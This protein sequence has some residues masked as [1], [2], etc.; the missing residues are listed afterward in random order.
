[1]NPENEARKAN[2]D[3]D[4]KVTEQLPEQDLKHNAAELNSPAHDDAPVEADQYSE[5][6]TKTTQTIPAQSAQP[7]SSGQTVSPEGALPQMPVPAVPSTQDSFQPAAQARETGV[8]PRKLASFFKKT[9]VKV[10]PI[11]GA[12]IIFFMAGLGSGMAIS[13][14]GGEGHTPG[15]HGA[16]MEPGGRMGAGKAPGGKMGPGV[17]QS[18]R[19]QPGMNQQ[20]GQM[21]PGGGNQNLPQGQNQQ[22][23]QGNQNQNQQQGNRGENNSQNSNGGT[24][25]SQNKSTAPSNNS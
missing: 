15:G 11:V 1:M 13:R 24:T 17:N 16:Q 19:M 10:V 14:H 22:Q 5:T 7:A 3:Q 9:W 23:P 4:S 20:P 6:E 21:A 12:L 8:K 2:L 25:D 18:D